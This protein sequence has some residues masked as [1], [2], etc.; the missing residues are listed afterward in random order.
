MKGHRILDTPKNIPFT[1]NDFP[2]L[3]TSSSVIAT[4]TIPYATEETNEKQIFSKDS[5]EVPMK[6]SPQL[7]DLLLQEYDTMPT[8]SNNSSKNKKPYW[9]V[10]SN[11]SSHGDNDV[12]IARANNPFGHSTKWKW[13]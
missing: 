11:R 3:T 9:P 12:F 5:W 2:E 10:T 6:I 13:R 7:S 8:T 4:E 1:T